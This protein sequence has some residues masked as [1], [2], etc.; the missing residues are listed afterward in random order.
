M[1]CCTYW[2]CHTD[3]SRRA[4][5]LPTAASRSV[6]LPAAHPTAVSHDS[7][8]LPRHAAQP[9]AVY[10]A[11]RRRECTRYR[12]AA[13]TRTLRPST[14]MARLTAASAA[15]RSVRIQRS[16]MGVARSTS[17]SPL[18]MV[19]VADCCGSEQR[20]GRERAGRANA[21]RAHMHRVA[22]VQHR[23]QD[24][25]NSDRVRAEKF[26]GHQCARIERVGRARGWRR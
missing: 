14:A 17:C 26:R 20:A 4:P 24:M 2:R 23:A 15:H 25:M 7:T 10:V 3:R 1:V 11:S 19:C 22:I 21:W 9:R 12:R 6:R 13:D 16:R 8:R 5:S 18:R